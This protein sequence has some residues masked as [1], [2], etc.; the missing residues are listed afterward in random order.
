MM[1][2]VTC[3]RW[4]LLTVAVLCG[5]GAAAWY[6]FFGK[7]PNDSPIIAFEGKSSGLKHS[8]IV[9]TLDTP[10]PAGKNVI[11]CS[12]F[13]IAW[14]RLKKDVAKG[15]IRIRNAEL[16]ADR[17]NRAKESAEDLEPEDYFA[18]AGRGRDGIVQKI[19]EE[20]SQK[21][22]DVP[23]PEFADK[24]VEAVAYAYLQVNVRF[25][26]PF[27]A[28]DRAL[29][30][31]GSSGLPEKVSSFGIRKM[32]ANRS[33]REQVAV[34]YRTPDL[35]HNRLREF[36]IDPCKTSAPYQVILAMVEEK[37]T[38]ADLVAGVESKIGKFPADDPAEFGKRD[39]LLIPNIYWRIEHEFTELQGKDKAFLGAA[40]EGLYLN[41]AFQLI[42]FKLGYRGAELKSEARTEAKK[43]AL[44]YVFDRPFLLYLKKR[45][46]G[47]PCFVM[48]VDNDELLCKP[49][50]G[51]RRGQ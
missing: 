18:A 2:K 40:L 15:P 10:L 37:P 21:F 32:D 49:G 25:S 6:F 51:V 29:P 28:N 43:S 47:R 50:F 1:A 12:S 38:L 16:V 26:I 46:A 13:Q 35:E 31:T 22:P 34:L 7:D 41:R 45:G 20:M 5:A 30:F 14:N 23:R 33:L 44:S 11:W 39:E 17:L 42:Y 24:D 8:V 4:A 27:F 19:Q 3:W 48:W 9:P 36:V